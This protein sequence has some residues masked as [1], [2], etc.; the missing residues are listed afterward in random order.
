M[1]IFGKNG[2]ESAIGRSMAVIEFDLHGN[3]LDANE[4]FL[5]TLGYSLAEIKGRHHRIFV[6]PAYAQSA[7]Y[8]A[9]WDKLSRGEYD[10]GQYR[11]IT[12]TG[13]DV[14]IQ[15]SYN[16]ILNALGKPS[17]VVKFATDVTAQVAA[18]ANFEGQI[19][20][21]SKAM[22]VI[23]FDLQGNILTANQNFLDAMGYRFDEVKGQH[24]RMFVDPAEAA[25]VDYRTFWDKLG[26]GEYDAG[27]YKRFGKGGREIW[28][29]ASYNPIRDMNGKPFKVV[30]FAT[31]ITAQKMANANYAGQIDAIG[32]S[33]AVIE[34]DLQGNILDA[35]QNFLDTLG[36]NLAE[37]KG[38]HHRMFVEPAEAN[39]AEYRAFWTKLGRGD[40]DAGQ[41]KRVGKAGRE[42]WIQASYNP[43]RDMNGK[44]FKV[45]KFATDITAQALAIRA[46]MAVSTTI[47]S[48][49]NEIMTAS[50]DLA[51]RTESQ[52]ATVEETAAT[53]HEVTQT[54][55]QNS[56]NANTANQRA[57]EATAAANDGGR[58]MSEVTSAMG[59]LEQSAEQIST[60]V[61]LIDEIA[62]QTNLLALNASVEAA[63]A[64]EAGKGFA[65][66]AQEVRALAQRSANASKDIKGLIQ[67]S[68]GEVR[69]GAELVGRAATALQNIVA[70]ISQV[71]GIIAEIS[72]ASREQANALDQIN[73][74]V[75]SIDE[76]TQRNAAMVEQTRAGAQQLQGQA[77]EL[78]HVVESLRGDVQ[79]NGVPQ[80][81]EPRMYLQAAE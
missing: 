1:A 10:A 79:H 15:A 11:R 18:N 30:K 9:F 75:T 70:S 20:A 67:K 74:A 72:S 32:K 68:N 26:R 42:I 38:Q 54:V 65:V 8:R 46:I 45:V 33:Q 7:E 4:N 27:Q 29:Q 48:A 53:M 12:K 5:K 40:Y 37:V 76:T 16:P 31:D 22:A 14:W 50:I 77:T 41:Y 78:E 80:S 56:E 58:I 66:V 25:G 61:G 19:A 28:I 51:Q 17:R 52:A 36:Y 39:T 71:G 44:P 23:E 63:R 59:A 3:I 47:T 64:G 69:H 2:M 62:F 21:I 6:D 35:N 13:K 60:I 34:F 55:R 24:H 81:N 57:T 43:I 73:T 49:S